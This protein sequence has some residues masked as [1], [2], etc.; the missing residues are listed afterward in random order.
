[1]QSNERLYPGEESVSDV[2]ADVAVK[3]QH[4]LLLFVIKLG[5]RPQSLIMTSSPAGMS[6]GVS[7]VKSQWWKEVQVLLL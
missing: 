2:S 4:L 7:I 1:M 5:L 6:G 3:T